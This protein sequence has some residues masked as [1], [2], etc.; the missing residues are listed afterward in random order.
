M[1]STFTLLPLTMD[2]S[3][4]AISSPSLSTDP[5]LTTALSNLNTLHRTLLSLPSTPGQASNTTPPPPAPVNPKRS[6]Q[7]QKMREQANTALKKAGGNP[8]MAQ[9][10]IKLHTFALKLA[11][12]RPAFEP[13]SLLRE[14][15]SQLYAQ[16]AQA[17]MAASQWPEAAADAACS[18]ELKR[19]GN[20]KAWWRRGRCLVEMGRWEEARRW[21]EEGRGRWKGGGGGGE[22][23][24]G[25]GGEV[26]RYM[27][28]GRGR[29][30]GRGDG[31]Q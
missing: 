18:V 6:A 21:V 24:E 27:E 20:G 25:V 4:K 28:R 12:T 23:V 29:W 2:P 22:G 8:A 26:K 1:D 9:E 14:E 16:R 17:Y 3:S 19:Q 11:L 30:G 31:I 13:T 7:I 10:A 15:A 5:A